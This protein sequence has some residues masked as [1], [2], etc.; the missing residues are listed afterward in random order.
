MEPNQDLTPLA[1]FVPE[2]LLR[3][4]S[5]T[6]DHA[7]FMRDL[8][9]DIRRQVKE[10][11]KNEIRDELRA[12]EEE[13]RKRRATYTDVPDAALIEAAK[14][15]EKAF[16]TLKDINVAEERKDMFL[17]MFKIL[18]DE[19]T[20]QRMKRVMDYMPYSPNLEYPSS[21]SSS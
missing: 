15:Y 13:K 7:Q 17:L 21:S 14:I 2:E 20:Q 16:K 19:Q 9:N 4:E 6:Q 3:K 5:L 1:R 18:K 10:E 12:E 11:L 8:R